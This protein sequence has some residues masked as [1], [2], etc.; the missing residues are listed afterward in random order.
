M[1]LAGTVVADAF[2]Q[3]PEV[4]ILRFYAMDVT[5]TDRLRPFL[6]RPPRGLTLRGTLAAL[7]SRK[8]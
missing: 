1:L 6:G 3:Q 5:M 8:P 4:T 2:Y 7:L